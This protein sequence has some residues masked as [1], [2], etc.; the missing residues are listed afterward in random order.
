[1]NSIGV[2]ELLTVLNEGKQDN[3][4][5]Y[6]STAFHNLAKHKHT[7][8]YWSDIE[9]IYDSLRRDLMRHNVNK[10]K[11]TFNYYLSKKPD[12]T[13]ILFD[14]VFSVAGATDIEDFYRK[15]E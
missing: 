15:A 11:R 6:L 2:K 9:S 13:D 1:M 8:A 10:F 5:D 4:L 12:E 3:I 14:E 7:Y